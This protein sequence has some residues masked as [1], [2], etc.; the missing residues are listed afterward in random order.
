MESEA[1]AAERLLGTLLREREVIDD[2]IAWLRSVIA[3]GG[4]DNGRGRVRR[5]P[6]G[7]EGPENPGDALAYGAVK[8]HVE[9]IMARS[10]KPRMRM[11]EIAQGLVDGGVRPTLEQAMT[12]ARNAVRRLIADG[13]AKKTG[14]YYKLLQP[15]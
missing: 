13:K 9:A 3:N 14:Y 2:R 6:G 11:N 10:E 4:A 12:S 1:K 15:H 7:A 5:E 8:A